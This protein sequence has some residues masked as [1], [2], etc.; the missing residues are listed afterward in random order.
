[1]DVES[2]RARARRHLEMGT[3]TPGFRL[4]VGTAVGVLNAALATE[5]ICVLRYKYHAVAVQG[6]E[7]EPLKHEFLEHAAD[8]LHHAD[9][10][11]ER[12]VQ[13]GGKPNFD[14]DG[15]VRRAHSQY[16]EGRSPLDM[17]REDL[18]AE[19]IAIESY[20]AMIDYFQGRDP[21]TRRLLEE[22]LAKEEE[23]ATDLSAFLPAEPDHRSAIRH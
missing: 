1:M 7:S 2:L 14:P 21:T 4:D 15:L 12:I 9:Q 10:L 19:R 5:L 17:A 22:I 20:R 23:H 13:L 11:A 8:E 16:A 18:I 6:P 3:L